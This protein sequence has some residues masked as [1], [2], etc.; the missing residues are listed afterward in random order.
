M[1]DDGQHPRPSIDAGEAADGAKG[2]ETG[3]LH[4]ILRI[5][6]VACEPRRDRKGFREM[7]HHD[8]GKLLPVFLVAQANPHRLK[9][10]QVY[11]PCLKNKKIPVSGIFDSISSLLRERSARADAQV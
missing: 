5:G 11:S 10:G 8:T 4:H 2:A 7:G 3:F 1:A 9:F 6:S